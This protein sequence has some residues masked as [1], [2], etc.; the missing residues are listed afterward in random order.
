MGKYILKGKRRYIHYLPY[1][2]LLLLGGLCLF[3]S[4]YGF[5]WSDETYC[6]ALTYRFLLGDSLFS[7][8][9]DIH[10]L[11]ALITLPIM[12]L[13]T[14][15]VGNTSGIILFMRIVF[16]HIPTVYLRLFIYGF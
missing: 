12:F 2:F 8:S 3:K 5:D 10:Q 14:V 11:S 7:D 16:C 13:Y 9:W 4:F 1:L 6:S 15:I